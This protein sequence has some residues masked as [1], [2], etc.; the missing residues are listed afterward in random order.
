MTHIAGKPPGYNTVVKRLIRQHQP[1]LLVCGHSHILRIERDQNN[2]LL[3]I[4][5]G[6]A[7]IHGFHKMKTLVRF[8]LTNGK[9]SNMEVIE[10]G[11]RGQIK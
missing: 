10:L 8:E 6:A 1:D 4:N 2:Q 9:I 7:G 5:P 11:L 3:L